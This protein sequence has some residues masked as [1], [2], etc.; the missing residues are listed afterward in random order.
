MSNNVNKV[1]LVG[2][3]GK[4][5][6][7]KSFENGGKIVNFSLATKDSWKDASGTKQEQTEWHQIVAKKSSSVQYME[8]YVKKGM[9]LYVEGKLRSRS[10][11]SK[12]GEDKSI[13][14]VVVEEVNILQSS[15]KAE[16]VSAT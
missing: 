14:E 3:V 7:I 11:K 9:L 8:Q 10:Y 12:S 16:D 15:K 6:E 5:P 2:H 1:I 13:A 4:N